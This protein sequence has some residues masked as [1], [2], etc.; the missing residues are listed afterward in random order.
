ME[1]CPLKLSNSRRM[2]YRRLTERQLTVKLSRSTTMKSLTR[3]KMFALPTS[4]SMR[5]TW[6]SSK[7]KSKWWRNGRMNGS[8]PYSSLKRWIKQDYSRLIRGLLSRMP[9]SQLII[10]STRMFSRNLSMPWS[11]TKMA[12]CLFRILFWHRG[13]MSSTRLCRH[14]SPMNP[15]SRSPWEVVVDRP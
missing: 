4:Q 2:W 3:L 9:R 11:S 13:W 10:N 6:Y 1:A 14:P 8:T 5:A 12:P 15:R 7:I